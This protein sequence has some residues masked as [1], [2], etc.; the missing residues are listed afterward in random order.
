MS[1]AA[2]VKKKHSPR[3]NSNPE[4]L[5]PKNPEAMHPIKVPPIDAENV[6]K[7]ILMTRGGKICQSENRSL[8]LEVFLSLFDTV[9]QIP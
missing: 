9:R 3:Q 4:V 2:T 7:A 8:S 1:N 6:R 5:F